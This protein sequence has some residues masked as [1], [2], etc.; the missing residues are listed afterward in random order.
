MQT[1]WSGTERERDGD[2]DRN[3]CA[4]R[5]GT[6]VSSPWRSAPLASWQPLSLQLL[7][8]ILRRAGGQV[9]LVTE[10]FRHMVLGE[11]FS[12]VDALFNG[13]V[14]PLMRCTIVSK[15]DMRHLRGGRG[16]T[17]RRD[18]LP[19]NVVAPDRFRRRRF[20]VRS[21]C[22]ASCTR[23]HQQPQPHP[24][25]ILAPAPDDRIVLGSGALQTYPVCRGPRSMCS[26]HEVNRVMAGSR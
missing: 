9:D 3:S 2:A 18:Y 13:L 6:A 10:G 20:T 26:Q 4:W 22:R 1:A 23:R 21:G 12:L 14:L 7:D 16:S 19:G 25:E 24:V 5:M 17:S 11:R 8:L 15:V